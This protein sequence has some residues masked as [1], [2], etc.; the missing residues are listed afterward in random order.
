MNK[1]SKGFIQII[2]TLV[3]LIAVGG[4]M[5]YFRTQKVK[6]N[7]VVETPTQEP[8]ATE[9][10]KPSIPTVKPTT[11]P[12]LG[13]KK[14][15]GADFEYKYPP[16]WKIGQGG[17]ALVSDLAGANITNFTKD[18]VMYNECMRVDKTEVKNGLNIKYQSYVASGEMCS[19]QANVRNKEIWITKAGGDGFQPGIIYFYNDS[20][21]PDGL[22]IFDQILS[23]FKFTK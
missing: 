14:Y 20:I 18:M 15:K 19:N 2:L 3:V 16:S 10:Q 12:T 4:G 7:V 6:P 23:T 22:N 5:Y 13:W 9:T 1:N 8:V 11:D 17:Q 21:Y